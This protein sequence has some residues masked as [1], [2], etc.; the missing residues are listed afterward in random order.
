MLWGCSKENKYINK[1]LCILWKLLNCVQIVWPT[2]REAN[3]IFVYFLIEDKID[4]IERIFI[5]GNTSKN[6][7]FD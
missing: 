7:I 2:N 4:L 3:G 6:K 5:N 1:I